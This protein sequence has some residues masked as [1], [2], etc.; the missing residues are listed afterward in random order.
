MFGLAP[1]LTSVAHLD[2]KLVDEMKFVVADRLF[3]PGQAWEVDSTNTMTSSTLSD[4]NADNRDVRSVLRPCNDSSFDSLCR[5]TSFGVQI[6]RQEGLNAGGIVPIAQRSITFPM[7]ESQQ[8]AIEGVIVEGDAMTSEYGG[9]SPIRDNDAS[10][11]G[12]PLQ[13][14]Y[15]YAYLGGV[16]GLP[17]EDP[18]DMAATGAGNSGIFRG[19][20]LIDEPLTRIRFPFS[21][22]VFGAGMRRTGLSCN[23]DQSYEPGGPAGFLNVPACLE[24]YDPTTQVP[25][26]L[27]GYLSAYIRISNVHTEFR[28]DTG[29]LLASSIGNQADASPIL[30]DQAKPLLADAIYRFAMAGVDVSALNDVQVQIADLPGATLGQAAGNII[31]LDRNA[32]GHGWFVDPTPWDDSEFTTLGDQGEQN[33][34]DA[35]T[36]IT[37]E[38]GH[39]LG[40]EHEDHGVMQ[41]TLAAGERHLPDD[42]DLLDDDMLDAL[43]AAWVER[44]P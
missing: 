27:T 7:T 13:A 32:A 26:P 43:V 35:L 37:H 1:E 6:Q 18:S 15:T 9:F 31:Y 42:L 4:L 8:F 3:F 38:L 23:A 41:P 39:L 21:L 11:P 19:E 10:D 2:A 34:I 20:D 44:G 24:P 16:S 14:Q 5:G 36:V 12:N 22:D 28:N 30:T 29:N 17:W 33:R 25:M 40:M